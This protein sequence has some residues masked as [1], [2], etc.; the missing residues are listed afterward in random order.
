[1]AVKA[2]LQ[3]TVVFVQTELDVSANTA[4]T[5][6]YCN[7]NYLTVLDLSENAALTDLECSSNYLTSLDVNEDTEV[8]C[9]RNEYTLTTTSLDELTEYGFEPA[10]AS[11]W[12]GA[13]YEKGETNSLVNITS[14]IV[15]YDYDAG[16]EEPITFT[17]K[18]DID[19][20][21]EED[22]DIP[23]VPVEPTV[24]DAPVITLAT[25]DDSITVS[26]EDTGADLYRIRRNDGSGWVNYKEVTATSF[27]DTAVASG[28]QYRYAVYAQVDGVW[29]GASN[30]VSGTIVATTEGFTVTATANGVLIEWG[31]TEGAEQ[32]RIRRK[33][34]SWS[35][36][37]DLSET[38]YTDTEAVAGKKYSY[39]VY[40]KLNGKWTMVT[41]IVSITL[42]PAAPTGMS[43]TETDGSVVLEWDAVAG[44]TY[45]LRRNDG[46][47][48]VDYKELSENTYVDTD[49]IA[50]ITYKYAVYACVNGMQSGASAVVSV[51]VS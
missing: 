37:V 13:E 38:S 5:E 20:P 26:W 8:W 23:D 24:P 22:P 9:E 49:V 46:S 3:L 16:A 51:S 21:A 47:G 33:D 17:L 6:L 1:M 30:I 4:L 48:W 41:E 14:D 11:N 28:T 19:K 27:T 31:E 7:S 32:Y 43:A 42:K 45:R 15:T 35:D 50:G 29:S 39:A 12:Q 2:Q 10:K 34:S 36:L 40:A 25:G 18:L 44:A